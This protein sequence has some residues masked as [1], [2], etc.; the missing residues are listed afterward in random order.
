[1]KKILFILMLAAAPAWAEAPKVSQS[2]AQAFREQ[3]QN[4]MDGMAQ[5]QSR[6]TDLLAE[7]EASAKA[8][9][10]YWAAYS[11][12]VNASHKSN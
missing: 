4:C 2:M 7:N 9:A 11:A 1:M 10:D 8:L 5:V 6:A 3:A 12:A